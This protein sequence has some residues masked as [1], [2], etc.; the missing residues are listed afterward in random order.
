[1]KVGHICGVLTLSAP[2]HVFFFF[3][4]ISNR[5]AFPA[6]YAYGR[7]PCLLAV[8]W[9]TS[10]F[11]RLFASPY[12]A[13][14]ARNTW[15]TLRGTW[16]PTASEERYIGAR[17]RVKCTETRYFS[18]SDAR[19]ALHALATR[20]QQG[21]G[22]RNAGKKASCKRHSPSRKRVTRRK[23]VRARESAHGC[24][25]AATDRFRARCCQ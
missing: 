12:T 7:L 18:Y 21:V 9:T 24:C 6:A 8:Q 20:A 16:S 1:M 15:D 19:P 13:R 25:P 3:Y 4:N 14:V 22:R 23:S 10:P 2:L 5:P 11:Q 17:G